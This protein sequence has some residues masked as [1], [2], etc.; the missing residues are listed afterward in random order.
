M[1]FYVAKSPTDYQEIFFR[2]IGLEKK[3]KMNKNFYGAI[4]KTIWYTA[5]ALW[6]KFNV[7]LVVIP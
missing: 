4:L 7:E 1:L 2:Q 5:M 6:I 3:K